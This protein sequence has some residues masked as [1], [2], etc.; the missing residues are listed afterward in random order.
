MT[1]SIV[2]FTI[3]TMD[4]ATGQISTQQLQQLVFDFE[5]S[6]HSHDVYQEQMTKLYDLFNAINVN[7]PNDPSLQEFRNRLNYLNAWARMKKTEI[8]P[9]T[10]TPFVD[11]A[12]LNDK[13]DPALTENDAYNPGLVIDQTGGGWM[14]TASAYAVTTTMDANMAEELEH[15]N[16]LLASFGYNAD[17]FTAAPSQAN[18]NTSAILANAITALRSVTTTQSTP[19]GGVTT[20]P[21]FQA[22][23]DSAVQALTGSRI[24]YD[25]FTGAESLQE[26]LMVDYVARGNEI[27]FNEMDLLRQ[28][29]DKNQ[30][31]LSYLNSLQDLMNQRDPEKFVLLLNNLSS[32][33]PLSTTSGEQW[34]DFEAANF[35][36]ERTLDPE[37]YF[38]T[39][40]ELGTLAAG[41]DTALFK[42]AFSSA[43]Q[44]PDDPSHTAAFTYSLDYLKANIEYIIGQ[45]GGLSA[46]SESKAEQSTG[47]VNALNAIKTDFDF[48]RSQGLTVKDWVEDIQEGKANDFQQHLSDA[49]V[50]S[51]SFNDT[52]REELRRVMFIFEEFYKSATGLLSRMTQIIEK[53]ATFMS[54]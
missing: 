10:G 12:T 8:N 29:I 1:Q 25:A 48:L 6:Q 51:Q 17:N 39:D 28:A 26:V 24:L 20:V 31:A 49:I 43:I 37:A 13:T 3:D 23:I 19:T 38:S 33:T 2:P 27:L 40:T 42:Q 22:A 41:N 5:I 44:N 7:D 35:G 45:V 15:V 16:R 21:V 52:Q 11:V 30:T 54:R 32:T 18:R 36:P 50:A 46:L 53:M 4:A 47:L 34:G 14:P 9:T